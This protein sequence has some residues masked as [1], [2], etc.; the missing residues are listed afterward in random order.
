MNPDAD[1][2]LGILFKMWEKASS[3]GGP[4]PLLEEMARKTMGAQGAAAGAQG[5]L[6]SA[7]GA[8]IP[9]TDPMADLIA[10]SLGGLASKMTGRPEP[11]AEAEN[12]IKGEQALLLA[13]RA[14]NLEHLGKQYERA[15][16]RAEKLDDTE[17][18]IKLR[19]LHDKKM[20]ERAETLSMIRVGMA[21]RADR[22][23]EDRA[24]AHDTRLTDRAV[25]NQTSRDAA[26]ERRSWIM[27]GSGGYTG[28]VNTALKWSTQEQFGDNWNKIVE[29]STKTEWGGGK[30]IDRRELRQR[31]LNGG[32]PPP[33]EWRG[34]PQ[35]YIDYLET[36]EDPLLPNKP[37]FDKSFSPAL[38]RL[39]KRYWPDAKLE[40]E[41]PPKK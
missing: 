16:N 11:Q 29:Q 25:A 23:K 34:D 9:R 40:I 21:E 4:D 2:I 1:P 27:A 26:A 35:R 7:R 6:E 39:V 24:R 5:Q 37:L 19:E 20:Q 12:L 33:E 17:N 22:L 14:E 38:V 41:P 13:Q 8:P 31:I 15:A 36:L 30:K 28:R 3:S 32:A 18:A 10:R